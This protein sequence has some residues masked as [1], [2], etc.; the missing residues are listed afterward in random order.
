MRYIFLL[1][2]TVTTFLATGQNRVNPVIKSTGGI[3]DISEAVE[4]PDSLLDYK[5]VIDMQSA[6]RDPDKMAFSINNVAR[7]INLHAVGGV[8]EMEIVGVI[9]STSTRAVMNNESYRERYGVDNPNITVIRELVSK[10]VKL[11]VCGQSLYARDVNP[12]DVLP[13]IKIA[14]AALTVLSTYQ[15]RGFAHLRF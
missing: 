3:F 12:N 15:L 6:D 7:M 13:E 11:F 2:F 1:V 5:L 8:K 10:G 14:T 4:L 9:H